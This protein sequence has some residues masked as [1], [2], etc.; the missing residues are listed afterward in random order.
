MTNFYDPLSSPPR[1][2]TEK[3]LTVRETAKLLG[4][5]TRSIWTWRAAGRI[6]VV[7]LGQ[8]TRIRLSDVMRIQQTGIS[9]D[10]HD[11]AA[12]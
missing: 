11:R 5:S 9:Y 4:V 12:V 7:K 2:R 1:P 8:V 3:L 10:N 6:P